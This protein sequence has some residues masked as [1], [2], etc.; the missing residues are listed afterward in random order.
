MV[1]DSY[2][3]EGCLLSTRDWPAAHADGRPALQRLDQTKESRRPI[4]ASV[5]LKSRTKVGDLEGVAVRQ[6][7]GSEQNIGVRKIALFGLDLG[8]SDRDR[9]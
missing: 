5:L 3:M 1:A 6:C 8:G 2:G 4:D 7:D 9:G